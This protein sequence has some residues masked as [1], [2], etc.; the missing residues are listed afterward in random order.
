YESASDASE[1]DLIVVNTCSVREKAEHKLMSFLG[2]LRREKERRPGLMIAVAGCVA[3][4]EGEALLNKESAIDVVIGPDN[5]PELP[6]LLRR[7]EDGAPPLVHTEFDVEAPGFL[8]PSASLSP[9]LGEVSTYVT[10]MK[11][12]DERCTYCIVPHTRGPERYRKADDIVD[13]VAYR[14]RLGAREV[15]LLGQTVN[16]WYEPE[17]APSRGGERPSEFPML[18]RRI[19]REVPE[20]TRLRYTSPHPRHLTDSL[21]QAHADLNVL[22]AHVHMP[23]Q[24]GSDRMLKRMLRRYSRAQYVSR[25]NKLKEV[26]PGITLSTDVIVG[27]PGETESDFEQ[28][29]SLIEEAGFVAAYCFKY[30]PRPH[31]PALKLGDDITPSVK[32]DRL[33]RLLALVEHQQSKHLRSLVGQKTKVLVEKRGR[34]DAWTGRSERHEIVHFVGPDGFD[35]EGAL[36]EVEVEKANK[37][38]LMGRL[39]QSDDDLFAMQASREVGRIGLE[40]DRNRRHRLRVLG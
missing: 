9:A 3:Q 21:V 2:T 31:T 17:D 38:S 16:S 10:V 26:R 36:V 34:N 8:E 25:V 12:C 23:V 28:T 19:A 1:V 7:V 35:L 5:I 29:L 20:L 18:L 15:T 27:F 33:A 32:S 37:H 14:V 11:G 4:Q 30:S 22:P 24:S 39:L 13:E 40:K 6:A